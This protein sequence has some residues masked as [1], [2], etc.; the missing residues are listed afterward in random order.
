MKKFL[1]APLMI[2]LVTLAFSGCSSQKSAKSENSLESLDNAV[3]ISQETVSPNKE[4]IN[5]EKDAIYCT[6]TIYQQENNHIIVDA[7]SDSPLF[8]EQQYS[9]EYD[10][11]ITQSDISIKWTTLMGNEVPKKED[12]LSVAAV[13]LSANGDIFSERKIN[14]A[15]GVIDIV[16]DKI[17]SN[18]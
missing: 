16:T 13:S 3:I 7:R 5:S 4:Y 8:K 14:F 2:M 15:K 6:V 1:M 9:V 18:Q 17:V 12:Q 10:K 11:K